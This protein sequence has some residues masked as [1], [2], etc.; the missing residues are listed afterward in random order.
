MPNE[1]HESHQ[2]RVSF[3]ASSFDEVCEKCGATDTIG[4]W[5]KLAEPC[6][7]HPLDVCDCGDYRRDHEN[8]V[9]R[10]TMPDDLC[11]GFRPCFRF[12][13]WE[14]ASQGDEQ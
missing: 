8:G 1:R 14:P 11:H 12:V 13:L 7:A 2:T 5:G 10:C 3:D 9:G 6:P 4:G